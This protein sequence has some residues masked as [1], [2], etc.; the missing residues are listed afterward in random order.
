[1]EPRIQY[2]KTSDGMSIAFWTLGEG[3][4]FVHMPSAPF[5]PTL[6]VWHRPRGR[7]WCECLAEKRKFVRYDGRGFGHS[8]RDVTDFSVEA[9]V[10]DLDA[11]VDRLASEK[12]ALFGYFLSGP[13]AIA[14]AARHPERVSH[15]ILWCTSPR[16]ADFFESDAQHEALSELAEKDWTWFTEGFAHRGFGWSAS[17]EAREYAVHLRETATPAAFRAAW[18]AGFKVD[19]SDLVSQVRSPT[20]VMQRRGLDSP[21]MDVAHG[22]AARIPDA[23]LIV[24]EG[25]LVI[26]YADG[27]EDVLSAI[28][29]FLGYGPP[30]VEV[31]LEKPVDTALTGR[32]AE[33]LTLVASGHSNKE[34]AQQLSLSVHTV[35]RHIANIYRK[36][37]ARGR[38]D[39]TAYALKHRLL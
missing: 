7:R 8:D 25:E 38:A 9:L 21:S 30:Q 16:G 20:L 18:D 39:A 17:E 5:S 32:E 3:I 27:M 23:R 28:D 11:V 34:I 12:V 26:P 31:D 33:V 36:I 1:M 19:V 2:A 37:G 13:V 15:L 4:P 22:L 29:E 10:M 35:Q 6:A 24:V 14:Y